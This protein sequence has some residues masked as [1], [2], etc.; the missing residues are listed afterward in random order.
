MAGKSDR[1]VP[2][3]VTK[4][5]VT[6]EGL[7]GKLK[8]K[9]FHAVRVS[10]LKMRDVRGDREQAPEAWSSSPGRVETRERLKT[11]VVKYELAQGGEPV[12]VDP[13]D[14]PCLGL[15]DMSKWTAR[16]HATPLEAEPESREWFMRRQWAEMRGYEDETELEAA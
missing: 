6:A 15:G 5:W 12:L 8:A 10:E 16:Q 9:S 11:L 3:R 14:G 7:G 2:V 13:T 1:L 4:Q